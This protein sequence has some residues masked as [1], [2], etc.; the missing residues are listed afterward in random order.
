MKQL[1]VA[2]P[3]M[4]G[5]ALLP[6]LSSGDTKNKNRIVPPTRKGAASELPTI[7]KVGED[8]VTVGKKTYK[9]TSLTRILV[10]GKKAKVADLRSGMQA[11]VTG[12][13]LR[14]GKEASDTIYKASRIMAKTDNKLEAKRRE[15]NKKQAERAREMN[16]RKNQGR[17]RR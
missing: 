16:R 5:I 4:A 3:L 8:L 10:N 6:L 13:V 15:F 9:V 11:S 14:Y 12:G 17:T 1:R 7:R 2:L